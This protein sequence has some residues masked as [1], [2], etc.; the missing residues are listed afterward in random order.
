MHAMEDKDVSSGYKP[1][2]E[3]KDSMI[4]RSAA[5]HFPGHLIELLRRRVAVC[6]LNN[7]SGVDA[8]NITDSR[9]ISERAGNATNAR[10]RCKPAVQPPSKL[11]FLGT[12]FSPACEGGALD[13][14]TNDKAA[15]LQARHVSVL[16]IVSVYACTSRKTYDH[17]RVIMTSNAG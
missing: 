4:C 1:Q 10:K 7:A 2:L 11:L 9:T 14:R 17:A 12:P 5:H 13:G 8:V 3:R 6:W 15:D 16:K